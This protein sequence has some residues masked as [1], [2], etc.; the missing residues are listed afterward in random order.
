LL[1]RVGAEGGDVG[2]GGEALLLD[3]KD[4]DVSVGTSSLEGTG[5]NVVDTNQEESVKVSMDVRAQ[6]DRSTT[7]TV[8]APVKFKAPFSPTVAPLANQWKV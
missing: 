6:E 1:S 8:V 5:S 2:G 3:D 7:Y 4:D